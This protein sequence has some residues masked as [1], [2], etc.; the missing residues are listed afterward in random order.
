MK[1]V[2][3]EMTIT[4]RILQIY[5]STQRHRCCHIC[6]QPLELNDTIFLLINNN[7]QF[8]N[9]NVHTNC[10]TEETDEILSRD[11]EKAKNYKH[12]FK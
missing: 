3:K 12:W 10:W 7:T 6:K 2:K 11:W 5:Y 8:P 1:S 4:K 9:C